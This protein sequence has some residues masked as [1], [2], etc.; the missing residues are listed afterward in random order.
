[1]TLNAVVLPAPFGPISPTISPGSAVEG[2]AVER[3]DA[4]ETL[5]DVVDFEEGHG[6]LP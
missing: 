3:D 1:M 2:H 6:A 5:G 4:A